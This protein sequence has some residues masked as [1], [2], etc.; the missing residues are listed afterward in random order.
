MADYKGTKS[1]SLLNVVRT[2]T[3]STYTYTE[4]RN[5]IWLYDA[6]AFDQV[7]T[8]FFSAT[9][10]V[11][12]G[13]TGYVAL[14]DLAGNQVTGSEVST[15]STTNVVVTSGDIKANLTDGTAYRA[16][17]KR[18]GTAGNVSI[19]RVMVNINQSGAVTKTETVIEIA[20]DNNVPSTSYDAP[21]D[22]AVF[23]FESARFDGTLAVY[24][25]ADLHC[26]GS[27]DTT[28]AA[29]YD[30]TAAAQ[31]ASSEVSHTGDTTTTRKRSGA[32]TLV[33]GH[34]YR[35]DIKGTSTSDDVNAVKIII[36]QTG[37]P[38]KTDSYIPI[39]NTVSS[40]SGTSYS[41]QNRYVVYNDTDWDGDTV[42]AAFE[43]TLKGTDGAATDYYQL[44]NDTDAVELAECTTSAT[45]Y[46]RVRDTTVTM[47]GDD[48][49][50]LNSG[51]K[52]TAGTVSVARGFLIMQV[53]W[54]ASAATVTP[55]RMLMGMGT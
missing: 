23:L 43:S 50:Q 37:T 29:L 4:D 48:G 17:W 51:R 36:Q 32:I 44:Y 45:T 15:T 42:V 35:A 41:Y 21:A 49:N 39:L 31:V 26:N 54:S 33:D 52:A 10:R 6:D 40:G 28:Y 5:Q 55:L 22:Y 38:T 3:S 53:D 19:D 20:E 24:L 30:L 8:I 9:L 46:T 27:G 2:T 7:A 34:I 13:D 47:P 12:S 14:Y 11:V 18:S 1:V 25:E 16:K